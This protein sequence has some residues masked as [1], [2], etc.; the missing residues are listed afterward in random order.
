MTGSFHHLA[1]QVR[2]LE[3]AEAFY[4]GLLGLPVSVRH[5]DG[6]G[7]PRSIWLDLPGGGFL[8]L[9]ACEGEPPG[10]AFRDPT[11][12]LH[13]LALEIDPKERVTWEERLAS[14]GF[15]KVA[16]TAFTFY[17]LDPEGNRIGLSHYPHPKA[18]A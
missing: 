10:R 1:I 9:E 17:V 8:A 13:L 14:G 4:A 16:E 15:G 6:A 11:P 5:D 7:R 12:G 18:G 3:R 2:D